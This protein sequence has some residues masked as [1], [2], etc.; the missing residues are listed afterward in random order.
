MISGAPLIRALLA[1]HA[2]AAA[3]L[4]GRVFQDEAP[5][6]V[7]FPCATFTC[8]FDDP[9]DHLRGRSS[10]KRQRWQ[11]DVWTTTPADADQAATAVQAALAVRDPAA[12]AAW[13]E[14][15]SVEL[16]FLEQEYR[17]L[18]PYSVVMNETRP[19]H[20]RDS[21]LSRF[22]LDFTLWFY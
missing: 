1:I 11:L 21:G 4:A 12:V 19:G 22:M 3:L 10:L 5:Q 17:R 7:E 2:P 15:P 20:D 14:E 9:Q 18:A 16:D 13:L 6:G 8:V